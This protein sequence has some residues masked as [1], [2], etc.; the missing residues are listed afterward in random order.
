MT[1]DELQTRVLFRDSN[2][3][4]L[5]KPA[6]LA[7]HGGPQT[8]VHLEA[9]LGALCFN[10]S[11]PPKLAHR[12]DRD[13][14]GCLIL[15]RHDKALSRLGKLFTAGKVEKTYWA[16]VEGGPAADEGRI[17]LPL[18]KVSSAKDGWRMIAD[19]AGQES[20]TRWRVLGRGQ[21]L[22][23]W[24]ECRPETGRTHQ[25]RVHCASGLGSAILGDPVY[26]TAGPMLHLQSHA[27]SI[28]YWADRPPITVEAPPPSHI[29][30]A[31]TA[32]GWS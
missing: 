29:L 17:D 12:L 18:K 27:V 22:L 2:L 20:V 24:L 16:V 11:Q 21:G 6:G 14:A 8:P 1:P 15:A 30:D 32:C 4:L 13:T 28:P 31:L 19:P 26:G 7:V 23:C 3:I 10:L 9:M 5:D 25:I